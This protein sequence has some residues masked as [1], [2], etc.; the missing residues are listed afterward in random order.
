MSLLNILGTVENTI[1]DI[2]Q[3]VNLAK[4]LNLRKAAYKVA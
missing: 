1:K 3:D 2:S 4:V